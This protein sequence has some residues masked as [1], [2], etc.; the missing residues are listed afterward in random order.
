MFYSAKAMK[1]IDILMEF[2]ERHLVCMTI[3]FIAH[4]VFASVLCFDVSNS[5]HITHCNYMGGA[6]KKL[7]RSNMETSKYKFMIFYKII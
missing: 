2:T 3:T 5:F 1:P 4:G 6:L 7:R